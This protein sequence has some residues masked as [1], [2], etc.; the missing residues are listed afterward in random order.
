[1]EGPEEVLSSL[2]ARGGAQGGSNGC[3][4][5][6][7]RRTLGGPTVHSQ[8]PPAA[9]LAVPGVGDTVRWAAAPELWEDPLES[10]SGSWPPGR[11]VGHA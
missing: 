8:A 1:M 3:W 6:A 7:P 2:P 10:S 5:S 11:A 4:A 9:L